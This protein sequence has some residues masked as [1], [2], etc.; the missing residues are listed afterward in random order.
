MKYFKLN[1]NV[2]SKKWRGCIIPRDELIDDGGNVIPVDFLSLIKIPTNKKL[3]FKK[4]RDGYFSPISTIGAKYLLFDS[5]IN[6][7]N[8]ISGN[9]VKLIPISDSEKPEKTYL[10]MYPFECVDCVNWDL[11]EIDLWPSGYVPKE[12]ESKRGRFFLKP[13]IHVNKIPK[14]LDAFCLNE[15]DGAF[16]IIISEKLKNKILSLDFDHSFLEFYELVQT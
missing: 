16:N 10:I 6:K 5:K 12:W 15:W 8:N 3:F 11:S 13:A 1:P 4:L 14:H 9:G 2:N 7:I